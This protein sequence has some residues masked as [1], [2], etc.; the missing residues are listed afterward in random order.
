MSERQEKKARN[1]VRG[2]SDR[3]A[4]QAG[5]PRSSSCS[6]VPKQ[7]GKPKI[8][9]NAVESDLNRW[10]VGEI[11]RK[12]TPSRIL[13]E[14]DRRSSR[15]TRRDRRSKVK[16]NRFVIVAALNLS[17]TAL[18]K[19]RWN[20]KRFGNGRTRERSRCIRTSMHV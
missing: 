6:K 15:N 14:E 16:F 12:R 11:E 3:R 2:R 18:C 20:Y 1:G 5:E 9:E 13:K 19:M 4:E 10:G 8:E 17:A 7:R